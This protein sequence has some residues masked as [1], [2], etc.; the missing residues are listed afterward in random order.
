MTS[1]NHP[2]SKKFSLSLL[3]LSLLT[4]IFS[5]SVT[6]A[7]MP[8]ESLPVIPTI[9]EGMKASLRNIFTTGQTNGHRSDVFIKAG[10]SITATG[11][12]LVDVGCPSDPPNTFAGQSAI[13]DFFKRTTVGTSSA[14]CGVSNSFT[15]DS[16]AAAGNWRTNALLSVATGDPG[17]RVGCT[18]GE[19]QL[20]CEVR[21]S[22]PAF[23][24]VMIGTND[25]DALAVGSITLTD[26]K[27]QITTIVNQL[28]QSGV[29]PVLSTL[30]PRLDQNGSLQDEVN[31]LNQAIIE[32]AQ[33]KNI[34]LWNY[35]RALQELGSANNYGMD[36]DGIHP[37][38]YRGDL[39][40][41]MD[42]LGLKYG[43]NVRNFTALQVLS[44]LKS[45]VIDNAAADTT[46]V[47]PPIITPVPPVAPPVVPTAVPTPPV[48]PVPPVTPPTPI[49]TFTLTGTPTTISI[50][51]GATG[52]INLGIQRT[53]FTGSVRFSYDRL[54][55]NARGTFNVSRTT[56]NTARFTI[57]VGRTVDP[58]TY[59][60]NI[61]AL[62]GSITRTIAVPITIT[63][64]TAPAADFTLTRT[65]STLSVQQGQTGTATVSIAR[66]NG[67]NGAV[68]IT[69]TG[70][71]A[72]VTTNAL[73][74]GTGS[75]AGTLRFS[76]NNTATVGVTTITIRATSGGLAKTI[77]LPL[78]ITR[79]PIV[80]APTPP[81]TPVPPT[82]PPTAEPGTGLRYDIG[83][84]TVRDIWVSPNGNDNNSG[85]SRST[86]LATLG[87]AWRM[88][89]SGTLTGTGYR[90]M[91]TAGTYPANTIPVYFELKRGT[92]QFPIIIQAADGRGTATLGGYLNIANVSHL[93]MIDINIIPAPAGDALH[94]ERGDHIL[95][96]GMRLSGG[97]RAAHETIKINQSQYIYLEDSEV[98]G[99]DDNT[100]DYVAVQYGHI[101]RNKISNANDWC[102]YVKGGSANIRV[103][104]NEIFNCGTGGFTTGQGTGFEYMVSPWLHYEAYG[105]TFVNNVIHDTQGAGIGVNGGFNIV[106][107]HNTMYRVGSTSHVIEVVFGGRECDMDPSLPA[108][109]CSRNLAA[110]GWGSTS[111]EGEPIPNKNVYI[112]NNIVYN[113][114]GFQSQWQHFAI[115]NPRTASASTNIPSPARTDDNLVIK[116]NIIWNG[117]TDH[118]LGLSEQA[119]MDNNPTCNRAQLLQDN[120]INTI[121]PQLINPA[122]GDFRP[123]S[124]SNIRNMTAIAIPTLSWS[125]L[126]A[127]P[128]APAGAT[129]ITI[130][131]N[132]DGTS[133]STTNNIGA[134]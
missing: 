116:G 110:G 44:K 128:L 85:A 134:Y 19:N 56:G 14:W 4:G 42:S 13:V 127:R 65:P 32:V 63:S 53:N 10:D 12:F 64:R 18:N 106:M 17:V 31:Q 45:I 119:C 123:V 91:M 48:T 95:M 98:S 114:P 89:P 100:I 35:W 92:A 22:K 43:Y 54:P 50:S 112:L 102:A 39:A 94:I 124:G 36:P 109:T 1:L 16:R 24:L 57:T 40:A 2:F 79:A 66:L 90:I 88:I 133:R 129:T 131:I 59:T 15:K 97:N 46:I 107:A 81:T 99:A 101:V 5:A 21:Q 8:A 80:T 34:P 87:A 104:G 84:P 113:P 23:A 96:R 115:Y 120:A 76:A 77:T 130:S 74:I 73:T 6:R 105:I 72:G 86:P 29:I 47:T 60:V 132:R 70:L 33:T 9:S 93:Y 126:P 37:N 25:V 28:Q 68:A 52:I 83:T 11:G 7:A 3:T 108:D 111:R 69:T 117:P 61:R 27:N 75:T 71:P 30:P 38:T 62:S 49:S 20:A 125:A 26:Y 118:S 103:E 55:A 121:Q 78:T 58:G 51:Q 122:A 41:T 67:F 82:T